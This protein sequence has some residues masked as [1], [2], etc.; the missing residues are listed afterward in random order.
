MV[1]TLRLFINVLHQ[2]RLSVTGEWEFLTTDHADTAET[3]ISDKHPPVL[4]YSAAGIKR[5]HNF[6]DWYCFPRCL[7]CVWW[8]A[9]RPATAYPKDCGGNK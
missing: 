9:E 7:S 6:N 8:A 5:R 2:N 1:S 3:A 4:R